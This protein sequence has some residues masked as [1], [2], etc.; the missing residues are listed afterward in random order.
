MRLRVGGGLWQSHLKQFCLSVGLSR[1]FRSEPICATR[2]RAF[3]GGGH[4]RRKFNF[5]VTGVVPTNLMVYGPG[6]YHFL[7]YRQ[8]GPSTCDSARPAD[9]AVDSNLFPIPVTNQ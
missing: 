3:C 7:D 6:G 5:P 4:S 8:S 2:R 1:C 9:G